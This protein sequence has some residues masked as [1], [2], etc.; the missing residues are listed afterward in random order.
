MLLHHA[1]KHEYGGWRVWVDTLAIVHSKV[2]YEEFKLQ[3]AQMYEHYERQRSDN[4]TDP[5]VRQQRPISTIS[6]WD[7]QHSGNNGYSRPSAW[8]VQ[9]TQDVQSIERN[10]KEYDGIEG[11]DRLEESCSCDLNSIDNT[12]SDGSPSIVKSRSDNLALPSSEAVSLDSRL[13]EKLEVPAIVDN[14]AETIHEEANSDGLSLP[15]TQETSEVVSIESS[16]ELYSEVHKVE[17]SST[18]S[19]QEGANK[20]EI[21]RDEPEHVDSIV[22]QV[23]ENVETVSTIATDGSDKGEVV[24]KIMDE[25]IE[26]TESTAAD[27]KPLPVSDEVEKVSEETGKENDVIKET[28]AIETAKSPEVEKV[29]PEPAADIE[30]LEK[31]VTTENGS[32]EITSLDSSDKK[33]EEIASDEDK[34]SSDQKEDESRPKETKELEEPMDEKISEVENPVE[35]SPK[36]TEDS[37]VVGESTETVEIEKNIEVNPTVL[38]NIGDTE[39]IELINAESPQSVEPQTSSEAESTVESEVKE[40]GEERIEISEEKSD[41]DGVNGVATDNELKNGKDDVIES[42]DI[43]STDESVVVTKDETTEVTEIIETNEAND[44]E[45]EKIDDDIVNEKDD[46]TTDNEHSENAVKSINCSTSVDCNDVTTVDIGIDETLKLVENGIVNGECKSHD[47]VIDDDKCL[48]N[49]GGN[50]NGNDDNIS[51]NDVRVPSNISTSISDNDVVSVITDEVEVNDRVTNSINVQN[52]VDN[53]TQVPNNTQIPTISTVCDETNS[54][55]DGVPQNISSNGDELDNL[56]VN[57]TGCK[58]EHDVHRRASLPNVAT[59]S[60]GDGEEMM[61]VTRKHS[62]PQKRPRS[63]STS[64]QVDPNHFGTSS[65]FS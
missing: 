19:M 62:S 15:T 2:S 37:S 13:S 27:E 22:V 32:C 24:E 45:A 53:T 65:M 39:E 33:T 34:P 9:Q 8:T 6:G 36:K 44:N 46:K 7:Q 14:H 16:S 18:D 41:T 60:C 1:I 28:D 54:K 57:D 20:E 38:E 50:D 56:M 4:I 26:I 35:D 64:T 17:S 31:D 47:N 59:D 30:N 58:G 42:S 55:H 51:G 52:T 21:N 11:N 49:G 48:V 12:E 40:S 5:E 23:V 61:P 3:F 10:Y 63:A 43:V 29:E 25:K